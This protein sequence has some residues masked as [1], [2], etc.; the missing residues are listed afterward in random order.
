LV[1]DLD[2]SDRSALAG[3]LSARGPAGS[4]ACLLSVSVLA[5]GEPV[6]RSPVV[7]HPEVSIVDVSVIALVL[8]PFEVPDP[9]PVATEVPG[10]APAATVVPATIVSPL[11]L[12]RLRPFFDVAAA[13]L[14]LGP[15][16]KCQVLISRAWARLWLF[17]LI[18]I[19]M[20]V[21]KNSVGH[22]RI[23]YTKY[24]ENS[25]KSVTFA[26]DKD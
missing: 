10:P 25:V 23:Y 2:V 18:A 15:L 6:G 20:V 8:V 16:T 11:A 7:P 5:S 24:F 1:G 19:F 22:S 21:E 26:G 4:D 12:I 17:P 9:A 13:F 14:S 3:G